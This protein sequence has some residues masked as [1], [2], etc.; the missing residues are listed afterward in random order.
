MKLRFLLIALLALL[1]RE[2]GAV[3]A[4]D[5]FVSAPDSIVP[6]L[7]RAIRLDMADYYNYGTARASDNAAGGSAIIRCASAKVAD[8]SIDDGVQL[9]IALLTSPADT[10]VAVVTTLQTPARDSD[11]KYYDMRWH[12]VTGH[13]PA[14]PAYIDWML[15]STGPGVEDIRLTLPLIPASAMFNPA[16]DTLLITHDAAR[17]LTDSDYGRVRP[18][19]RDAITYSIDGTTFTLHP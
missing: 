17:Y 8:I 10:L 11:I 16:A 12:P 4:L 13:A 2:A 5:C 9:Q 3:T 19:L 18:L 6:L 7:P 1:G 14:M 15:D